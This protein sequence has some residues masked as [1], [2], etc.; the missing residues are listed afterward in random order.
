M[1]FA[2]PGRLPWR[3][4]ALML[5]A[6]CAEPTPQ[7]PGT[8]AAP[9]EG[10]GEM[11]LFSADDA[12][13]HRG[14]CDDREYRQFDFW[15]GQWDVTSGGT[16]AGT[17]QISRALDG[18]AVLESYAAMGFIG[19]SLN[20]YDAATGQWHQHWVDHTGLVLDLFGGLQGGSMVLQG[21]RPTPA[22]SVL[23]R[24]TW[25]KLGPGQVRQFWQTST[26]GGQSFPGVQFDGLYQRVGSITPD[27]ETPQTGCQDPTA[28]ALF[29]FDYTLGSWE[30]DADGRDLRSRIAKDLSECLIEERIRGH[31]GYEAIVFT[32]VRRRLGIW[33]K[34]LV[35]NRGTNAFL[36]GGMTNGQMILTGTAP[37]RHGRGLDVRVTYTQK[38]PDRFEQ[39]WEKTRDGG[40]TWDRLLVVKYRRR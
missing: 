23:D 3:G 21:D 7:G 38:S 15:V 1:Q 9:G 6:G 40:T 36:T 30:V 24:I 35:D 19:R 39:R 8:D 26:D 25:T 33:T 29:E 22:G 2:S 4:L 32:S 18:C 34:T 14:R 37:S 10:A 13:G 11:T 28:P 27:P 20:S 31:D 12:A 17:N 16:P 5:L